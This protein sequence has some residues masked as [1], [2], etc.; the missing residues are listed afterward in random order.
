MSKLR[1]LNVKTTLL[2][3]NVEDKLKACTEKHPEFA[4]VFISWWKYTK[5]YH[6][7][8]LSSIESLRSRIESLANF[9]SHMSS[10]GRGRPPKITSPT[11]DTTPK[12]RGRPPKYIN[13]ESSKKK[14]GRPSKDKGEE[15]TPKKK[16]GRPP[17]APAVK[18][19]TPTITPKKRGRPPKAAIINVEEP[20]LKKKRG[21]PPKKQ[22]EDIDEH[23]SVDTE[24]EAVTP[25]STPTGTPGI[26]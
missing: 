13:V 2:S 18:A 24:S 23:Q 9:L 16:R 14:R 26:S 20:A 7:D 25:A 11:S 3:E 12:K 8:I 10:P 21:R 15:S 1:Q 6:E 19:N 17:K 22:A 4:D 5:H